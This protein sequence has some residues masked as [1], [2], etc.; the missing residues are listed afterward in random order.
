[1]AHVVSYRLYYLL[2]IHN[3]SRFPSGEAAHLYE[4]I[5]P[6]PPAVISKLPLSPPPPSPDEFQLTSCPAC[7]HGTTT[8]QKDSAKSPESSDNEEYVIMSLSDS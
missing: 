4:E 3:I 1:M 5:K 6:S 2:T 8:Q 7:D